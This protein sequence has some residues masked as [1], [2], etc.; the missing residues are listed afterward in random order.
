MCIFYNVCIY[1]I[2]LYICCA[3][4]ENDEIKMINQINHHVAE[5]K[6]LEHFLVLLLSIYI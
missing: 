2:V 4:S 5:S 1:Y 3:L 6:A